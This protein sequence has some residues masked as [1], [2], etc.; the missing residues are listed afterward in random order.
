MFTNSG[1]RKRPFVA[2]VVEDDPEI[3]LILGDGLRDVGFRVIYAHNSAE[4]I[5]ILSNE[6][7]QDLGCVLLD[8]HL[9]TATSG[10]KLIQCVRSMPDG[11][12]HTPIL[13][14]SSF[15][16]KDVAARIAGKVQGMLA[17][18]FSIE[19]LIERVKAVSK[20]RSD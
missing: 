9:E 13:V 6:N 1:L 10:E 16:D 4:A 20:H 7:N 17:K 15:L 8:L 19:H 14:M 3:A 11:R 2:L 12:A 5:S 18:P